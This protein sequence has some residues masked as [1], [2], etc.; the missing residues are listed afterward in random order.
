MTESPAAPHAEALALARA[1][2]F[3]DAAAALQAVVSADPRDVASWTLMAAVR[4][5]LGQPAAALACYDTIVQLTPDDPEAHLARGRIQAGLSDV[6]EALESFDRAAALAPTSAFAHSNRASMLLRQNRLDEALAAADRALGLDD[7]LVHAWRH[8]GFALFCLGDVEAAVAAYQS[9]VDAADPNQAY[10]ALTDLAMALAANGR[11]GE[12]IAALDRAIATRPQA[13]EAVLRRAES[14]LLTGDFVGGWTDYEARLRHPVFLRTNGELSPEVR[15]RLTLSPQREDL[16]G[17]RV[18]VVGEQGLGDQV[19]F[20][21]VLPDL[22]AIAAEVTCIVDPRLVRLFRR[23]FPGIV[24]AGAGE[25]RQVDLAAADRVVAL[26][27][28]PLMFRRDE[29]QFSGRPYLSPSPDV[30]AAWRRRLEA[31]GDGLRIGLSWRG[32]VSRT[33]SAARSMDLADLRPLL[34]RDGCTFVSLQYGDVDAEIAAVNATLRRPVVS[35]PAA[36]TFDMEDLAGLVGAMDMVVTVQTTLAHV[37]GAMGAPGLVMIPRWPE[38][39]YGRQ[40][41]RM[42]WYGSLRLLRQSDAD[43]WSPVIAAIARRLDERRVAGGTRSSEAG[44]L[45]PSG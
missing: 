8:R 11:Y 41:E 44:T 29:S 40:G 19:M 33:R 18:L 34:D 42:V 31:T 6:A 36:E 35:F 12:A 17:R 24:F 30:T 32:G 13:A 26:G 21:S 10:E 15:G 37:T 22:A 45:R 5:R 23:S 2:R 28:L 38:W 7:S 14:R 9:G 20:A 16:A 1:G 3:E 25:G 4:Q 27:S 43:D 39:R